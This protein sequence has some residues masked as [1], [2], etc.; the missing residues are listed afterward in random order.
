MTMK[1][2]LIAILFTSSIVV[3]VYGSLVTSVTPQATQEEI[4]STN[5]IFELKELVRGYHDFG[6]VPFNIDYFP[7]YM[8]NISFIATPTYTSDNTFQIGLL[9]DVGSLGFEDRHSPEM[10]NILT[11]ALPQGTI[12]FILDFTQLNYEDVDIFYSIAFDTPL[13]PLDVPLPPSKVIWDEIDF[14]EDY[15]AVDPLQQNVN[16]TM[17]MGDWIEISGGG[18]LTAGH[19]TTST[20]NTFMTA[21]HTEAVVNRFVIAPERSPMRIGNIIWARYNSRSDVAAVDVTI[22][23]SNMSRQLPSHWSGI[24]WGGGSTITNFMGL[25][26]NNQQVRTIGAASGVMNGTIVNANANIPNL[27][28]NNKILVSPDLGRVGDSGAALIRFQDNAVLGTKRGAVFVNGSWHMHFTNVH[29][30]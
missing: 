2:S 28:L 15:I 10:M 4:I 11:R 27:N 19:P 24:P 16:A 8:P 18:R 30:Y 14:A 29:F 21:P 13:F 9:P 26:Q 17:R 3:P 6:I 7:A 25:A 12:D 5:R 1:K 22:S 20:G 23:G